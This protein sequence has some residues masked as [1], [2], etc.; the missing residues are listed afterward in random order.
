MNV[1]EEGK[2]TSDKLVFKC[3]PG[4]GKLQSHKKLKG[5]IFYWLLEIVQN[6][7]GQ[8]STCTNHINKSKILS[9]AGTQLATNNF[10]YVLIKPLYKLKVNVSRV[11]YR[12]NKKSC[13][14]P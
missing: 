10:S 11:N 4:V 3:V 5:K 13:R 7:K 8:Y 14:I 12:T 2:N 9:G 1:S 6:A